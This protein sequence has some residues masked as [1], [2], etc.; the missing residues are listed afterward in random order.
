MLK[1][2]IV[3]KRGGVQTSAPPDAHLVYAYNLSLFQTS[4]VNAPLVGGEWYAIA[5]RLIRHQRAVA[6]TE[7]HWS[8]AR[9][10]VG[11]TH[12]AYVFTRQTGKG[13]SQN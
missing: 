1:A 10:P 6:S 5:V 7:L 11:A 12:Y 2:Y 9:H 3:G 13:P 4:V 8:P